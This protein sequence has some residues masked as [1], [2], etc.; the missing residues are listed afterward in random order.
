MQNR[1]FDIFF[2]KSIVLLLR[3]LLALKSF[4]TTIPKQ[5]PN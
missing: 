2:F 5:V 1:D 3:I 4:E